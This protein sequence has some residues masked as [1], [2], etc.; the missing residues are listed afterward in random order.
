MDVYD[1]SSEGSERKER[2]RERLHLP[3]EYEQNVSRN[4]DGRIHSSESSDTNNEH[5]SRQQR[6]G[7]P[8]IKWQRTWLN[9]LL[10]DR[11]CHKIAFLAERI[12][13]QKVDV[14]P[15]LS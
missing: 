13:K 11:T 12:P 2:W 3:R 7:G 4:V 6:K 8:V 9:C 14:W 15:G 1:N 5:A 10:E